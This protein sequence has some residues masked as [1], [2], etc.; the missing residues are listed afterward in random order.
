MIEKERQ[1]VLDNPFE[2]P[3][4]EAWFKP[5]LRKYNP[6]KFESVYTVHA[7]DGGSIS[8]DAIKSGV[9]KLVAKD[10][11][12]R[13]WKEC[14]ITPVS[15]KEIWEGDQLISVFVHVVVSKKGG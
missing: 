12:R 15:R 9:N 3:I 10:L 2:H 6:N 11:D 8:E 7:N 4:P 14:T 5:Q 13:R 1:S